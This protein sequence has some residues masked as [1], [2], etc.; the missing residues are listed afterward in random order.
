LPVYLTR[1]ISSARLNITFTDGKDARKGIS[2]DFSC[3]GLFIRTRKGYEKGTILNMKLELD[4]S[5][6]IPLTGIVKRVI[7]S[8]ISIHKD[9]MGI[10]LTSTP[11]KY[12]ALIK[13]L[14]GTE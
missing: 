10:E 1:G 11:P 8:Q 4:N 6:E 12:D 2:S 5:P 7:K 14:L 13:E 9:G 3:N